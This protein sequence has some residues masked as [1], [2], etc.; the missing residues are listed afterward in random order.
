MWTCSSVY[1][2]DAYLLDGEIV[3]PDNE[4]APHKVDHYLTATEDVVSH[5]LFTV[6][7]LWLKVLLLCLL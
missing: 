7:F 6:V 4:D 3:H 1:C 5:I 2:H